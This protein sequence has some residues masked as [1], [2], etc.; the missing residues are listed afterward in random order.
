MSSTVTASDE[1]NR[2]TWSGDEVRRALPDRDAPELF[3]WSDPGEQAAIAGVASEVRGDLIL[4][5]GVG[6]GRTVPLLRLLSDRYIAIDYTPD[7]VEACRRRHPDVDVRLGDARDLAGIDDASVGLVVF[8]Y[9]GLDAIARPER[10]QALREMAR[11]LRPGGV[12]QFSTLNKDGPC[13]RSTPLHPA[14]SQLM[15]T[16][17]PLYRAAMRAM[18]WVHAPVHLPRAARNRRRLM[19]RTSAGRTWAVAPLEAF[20][21]GLLVHYTTLAGVR[22]ELADAGLVLEQAFDA[23]YGHPLDDEQDLSA[24]RY[25]QLVARKR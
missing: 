14:G 19:G 7:M 8:S 21:Y 22:R 24:V 12:L 17:S 11:V 13:Y 2:P 9:N 15:Y 10:A 4:D 16:W 23:E 1:V 25:F 18:W 3:S 6:A 5:L 20:D